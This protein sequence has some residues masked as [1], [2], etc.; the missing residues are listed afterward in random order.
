MAFDPYC[1]VSRRPIAILGA[2]AFLAAL[3]GGPSEAATN[4]GTGDTGGDASNV[5]DSNVVTLTTTTLSLVKRA[6]EADGTPI[7]DGSSLPR[8]T[9]V[10]F[11]LYINNNTPVPVD[12]LSIED[13]LSATFAFQTGTIKIDNTVG[14]CALAACT[15]AEEAAIF[16]SVDATAAKTDAID[17]DAVS[18]NA[19]A[20]T[21]YAGN[22]TEGNAEIDVAANSV[23]ALLVTVKMQ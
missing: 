21:I 23:I 9:F 3:S 18:Y 4:Q 7:T 5:N 10:K 19:G 6:F 1:A 22:E 14:D 13:V 15:G 8:G 20:T 2:I 16:A 12:D 17:A 11:L